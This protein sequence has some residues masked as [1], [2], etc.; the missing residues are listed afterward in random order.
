MIYFDNAATSYPKPREVAL[1]ANLYFGRCGA[2]PG[3]GGYKMSLDTA[4][5]VYSCRESICAL[6]GARDAEHV[7]FTQNCTHALNLAIKGVMLGGGHMI[8]SDLE[9]NSVARPAQTLMDAG[10]AQVS[11]ARTFMDEEETVQS[12]RSLLRPDTRLIVCTHASNVFGYVLPIEKIARMAHE[13]GVLMLVDAAQSAGVLEIDLSAMGLDFLCA[14]GHKGLMGPTGTGLLITARGEELQ[15]II[16]GGTGSSSILL[17][18]PMEMPERLESGT[19]NTLGIGMLKAGVE[20]VRAK[21]V[22]RI[23]KHEM[24]LIRSIYEQL[25]A[26]RGVILYTAKPVLGKSVPVLSFNIEGMAAEETVERLAQQGFAVRGGLHCS[27]LAHRKMGTQKGGTVRIS[28]GSA[29][30]VREAD[31]FCRAI[32][33]ILHA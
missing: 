2:N 13:N 19:V 5:M 21:G 6:L 14:A 30:T 33:K 28:T 24:A 12:F 10:I 29:N 9:H 31:A 3:R 16:E 4:E 20:Y 17:S 27:P 22:S 7:V 18:Q 26:M 15:T 8:I 23:Y 11:I 25:S 1:A 32:Q